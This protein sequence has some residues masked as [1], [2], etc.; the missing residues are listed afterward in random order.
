MSKLGR[1]SADRK[2][3]EDLTADKTVEVS[4]CG[5]IFTLSA[6]TGLTASLPSISDAGKGWWVKF[7]VADAPTHP[8]EI[9]ASSGDSTKLHGMTVH[10]SG[11]DTVAGGAGS[12]VSDFTNGTGGVAVTFI[13]GLAKQGDQVELVTDGTDWYAIAHCGTEDAITYDA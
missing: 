1:Y 3:I 10:A 13:G 7:V 5:T 4:D 2:K 11:S 6:A 9:S 12:D 8:Y